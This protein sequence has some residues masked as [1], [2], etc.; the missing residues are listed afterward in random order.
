MNVKFWGRAWQ[1]TLVL[2]PGETHGQDSLAGCSPQGCRV[3]H[4]WSDGTR[5]SFCVSAS[6][7]MKSPNPF[8]IFR[9]LINEMKIYSPYSALYSLLLSEYLK[10][11]EF[12]VL[13]LENTTRCLSAQVLLKCMY[14]LFLIRWFSTCAQY[15]SY[16]MLFLSCK[17]LN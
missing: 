9:W 7:S 15:K 11:T 13:S 16:K 3:R 2:L 5:L 4:D 8:L 14:L 12:F 6:I 1:P 17:T 10:T